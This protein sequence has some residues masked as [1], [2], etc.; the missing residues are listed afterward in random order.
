MEE[1]PKVDK[2]RDL[3]RLSVEQLQNCERHIRQ[4]LEGVHKAIRAKILDDQP[5]VVLAAFA[6]FE[7]ANRD[8]A[9]AR[10]RLEIA[11]WEQD[12]E[13]PLIRAEYMSAHNLYEKAWESIIEA[14][15]NFSTVIHLLVRDFAA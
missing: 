7:I 11:L 3:T 1:I 5:D 12:D 10:L 13:I 8:L 6:R 2:E 9:A 14:D 4:K 15:P